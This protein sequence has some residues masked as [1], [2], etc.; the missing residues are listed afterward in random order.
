M[1]EKSGDD[2]MDEAM[3]LKNEGISDL[4]LAHSKQ[5][6]GRQHEALELQRKGTAKQREGMALQREALAE[7]QRRLAERQAEHSKEAEE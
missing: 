1:A 7:Q 3:R 4:G 2:K 5:R 6:E